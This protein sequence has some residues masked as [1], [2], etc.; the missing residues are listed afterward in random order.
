MKEMKNHKIR[1]VRWNAYYLVR[2]L[3]KPVR[4]SREIARQ[5]SIR[6]AVWVV[7]GFAIYMAISFALAQKAY[8][9]PAHDLEVWIKAWGAFVMLPVVNIPPEHYRTFLAIIMLPL[10]GA[11]WMLMAGSAHLLSKLFGGKAPLK[12]WLNQ[13]VFT[14][15]PFWILAILMDGLFSGVFGGYQVPALEMQYGPFWHDFV[16]Y[17]PQYLYTVLYGIGAVYAGI[18]AYQT[19]R[20]AIWKAAIIG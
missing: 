17:F 10:M 6:P 1:T 16:L 2:M 20:F 3:F 12:V 9:P 14:F 11:A 19:E 13:A 18:A 4:T 7:L 15:F 5:T 8:P